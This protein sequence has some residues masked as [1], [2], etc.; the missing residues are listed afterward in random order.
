MERG[1]VARGEGGLLAYMGYIGS[2]PVKGMVFQQF[3]LG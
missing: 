2:A 1:K 3:P